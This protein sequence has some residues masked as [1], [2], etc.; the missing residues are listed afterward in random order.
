MPIVDPQAIPDDELRPWIVD[1]GYENQV[2]EAMSKFDE[3]YSETSY[4]RNA[5]GHGDSDLDKFRHDDVMKFGEDMYSQDR[6]EGGLDDEV[7]NG[8]DGVDFLAVHDDDSVGSNGAV[9][10]ML[11]MDDEDEDEEWD[12]TTPLAEDDEI[13]KLTSS[14]NNID[15]KRFMKTYTMRLLMQR[16]K[17]KREDDFRAGNTQHASLTSL[18]KIPT[19]RYMPTHKTRVYKEWMDAQQELRKE[20]FKEKAYLL[21]R[22]T[23]AFINSLIEKEREILAESFMK[24]NALDSIAE[25]DR[26]VKT[27]QMEERNINNQKMKV[28]N[29]QKKCLDRFNKLY[30]DLKCKIPS[31]PIDSRPMTSDG[32]PL[33]SDVRPST[34]STRPST[35]S[36]EVL[37]NIEGKF[38]PLRP[39]TAD[40]G[41][42]STLNRRLKPTFSDKRCDMTLVLGLK[43]QEANQFPSSNQDSIPSN[44]SAIVK[45]R[46]PR[47]QMLDSLTV[48]SKA[49]EDEAKRKATRRVK[50]A[51]NA[52]HD[53]K[54][55]SKGSES[56]SGRFSRPATPLN[57]L[58]VTGQSS[59]NALRDNPVFMRPPKAKVKQLRDL[60]R[61]TTGVNSRVFNKG[62]KTSIPFD[63]HAEKQKNVLAAL[64]TK[65]VNETDESGDALITPGF[66]EAM[67]P[68]KIYLSESK[69]FLAAD[70]R[71]AQQLA[72]REKAF[73]T[74]ADDIKKWAMESLSGGRQLFHSGGGGFHYS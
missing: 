32:R 50:L 62:L 17:K 4:M 70:E 10:H 7:I 55:K 18:K 11:P 22:P 39:L 56:N 45:Y 69:K 28:F 2:S 59:T 37:D 29:D 13:L 61:T 19:A 31:S 51:N 5:G 57:S 49:E 6:H 40:K 16:E 1:E 20:S 43:G 72:N 52:L 36:M 44:R 64:R 46:T 26:A 47:E 34:S 48:T 23:T 30:P 68:N 42:N 35:A 53:L 33:T 58:G 3:T 14:L 21:D 63:S 74:E 54:N 9:P 8:G 41:M 66:F 67:G 60:M 65:E 24:Q 27:R 71:H 73:V 12:D 25:E 15:E 38:S